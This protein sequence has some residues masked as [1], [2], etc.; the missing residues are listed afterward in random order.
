MY[1]QAKQKG[2]V[3]DG[4]GIPAVP[5]WNATMT[6]EYNADSNWT[7]YGRLTYTGSAYL[8]SANTAKVPEWY[9]LD[10]GVQYEKPLAGGNAMRVGLHV[11][12]A[13]NRKYW[14][15]RGNDTVALDGPRS[16]VL[17]LGYDF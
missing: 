15:A 17:S 1:L 10:L 12:N 6:A 13:L 7:A 4:K 9:R 8:T 5:Q 14:C 11:F 16:V 3:N 2:G